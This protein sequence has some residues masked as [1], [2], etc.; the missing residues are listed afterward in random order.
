MTAAPTRGRCK[1]SEGLH[2]R[3]HQ[4][5]TCSASQ[6]LAQAPQQITELRQRQAHHLQQCGPRCILEALLAVAKGEPL[7]TVLADF[8]RLPPEVYHAVLY[9]YA[10]LDTRADVAA[11]GLDTE[12]A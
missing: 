2:K 10:A 9:H 7:D 11:D 1:T 3:A 4:H 5:A 12:V 8:E 6:P